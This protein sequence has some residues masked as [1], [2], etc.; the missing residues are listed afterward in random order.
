MTQFTEQEISEITKEF[1]KQF[2]QM[3]WS[4]L[5]LSALM[6]E[7]ESKVPKVEIELEYQQDR[8]FYMNRCWFGMPYPKGQGFIGIINIAS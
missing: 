1:Q 7:V 8:V 6:K 2:E 3:L 5:S 4:E